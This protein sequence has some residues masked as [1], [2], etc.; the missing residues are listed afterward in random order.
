MW[1]IPTRPSSSD[2]K[3]SSNQRI[4]RL[5]EKE[6]KDHLEKQLCFRCHKPGHQSRNC[7]NNRIR[8]IDTKEDDNQS[9]VE[10][11][12]DTPSDDEELAEEE[13]AGEYIQAIHSKEKDF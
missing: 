2:G 7:P 8:A 13:L 4:R 6:H 5:T 1:C 9:K 12:F 3:R 10:D 11:D